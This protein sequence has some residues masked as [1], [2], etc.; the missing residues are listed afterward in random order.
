MKRSK[1]DFIEN[2]IHGAWV[3][4]G[5]IGFRQYYGFTKQ[6]AIRK[7]RAECDEEAAFVCVER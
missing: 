6:E 2:N 3:I 1:I 4:C 7:Y 5:R